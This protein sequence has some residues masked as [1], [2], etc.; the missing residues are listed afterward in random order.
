MVHKHDEI[1]DPIWTESQDLYLCLKKQF[2]EYQENSK[3]GV[4]PGT[5]YSTHKEFDREEKRLNPPL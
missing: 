1:R 3:Q 2:N 5:P 4:I